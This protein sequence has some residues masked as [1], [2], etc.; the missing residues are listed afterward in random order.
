MRPEN[1]EIFDSKLQQQRLV[2]T[3]GASS[4]LNWLAFLNRYNLH[5]ILCDEM[6]LGK[7]LMSICML[8]GDHWRKQENYV[9]NSQDECR[10]LTSLFV[11]PLTLTGHWLYEVRGF[12]SH[13][14]YLNPIIYGVSR[15]ERIQLRYRISSAQQIQAYLSHFYTDN[16]TK[17]QSCS[18]E[19]NSSKCS[20]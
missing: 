12:V 4:T 1:D 6:G 19:N 7:T 5:G 9:K 16:S 13:R 3:I 17:F 20:R 10:P 18:R 11:C 15:A 14:K 8:A 2:S